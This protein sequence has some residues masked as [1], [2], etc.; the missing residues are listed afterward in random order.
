MNLAD[1]VGFEPTTTHLTGERSTAELQIRIVKT[2]DNKK[3]AL[4]APLGSCLEGD[5]LRLSEVRSL[6]LHSRAPNAHTIAA[7]ILLLLLLLALV[8]IE[9][10]VF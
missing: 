6:D 9:L 10:H 5:P 4:G 2:W 8:V 7:A 1:L 3:G